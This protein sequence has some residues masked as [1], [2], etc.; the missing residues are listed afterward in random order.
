MTQAD[1]FDLAFAF[2]ALECAVGPLSL[3]DDRKSAD[4]D[5]E[6]AF[7]R[8]LE[9]FAA[10][11]PDYESIVEAFSRSGQDVPLLPRVNRYVKT[12]ANGPEISFH[13]MQHPPELGRLQLLPG[14]KMMQELWR[15][16]SQISEFKVKNP[17]AS[18]KEST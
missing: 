12:S 5:V 8:R 7:L 9:A 13:F 1:D 6:R 17:L 2:C 16:D 14:K 3:V 10:R 11:T 18:S 15:L 4:M